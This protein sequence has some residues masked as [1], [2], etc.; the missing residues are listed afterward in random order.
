[1]LITRRVFTAMAGALSVTTLRDFNVAHA[2]GSATALPSISVAGAEGSCALGEKELQ[3]ALSERALR[4]PTGAR[5][6]LV[7]L[8]TWEA[9]AGDVGRAVAAALGGGYRHIDCAPVYKNEKEVGDAI[10]SSGVRRD[11]LWLT[12]KL[13]NDRRRPGVTQWLSIC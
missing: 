10:I 11:Q 13:W 5:M 6:P 12:S 9:P 2:E 1:M 3:T 8:G 4:L 7:G